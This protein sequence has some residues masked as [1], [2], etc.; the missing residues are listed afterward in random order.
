MKNSSLSGGVEVPL[1]TIPQTSQLQPIINTGLEV[2][3]LIVV[4]DTNISTI[5]KIKQ[6][7]YAVDRQIVMNHTQYLQNMESFIVFKGIKRPQ[8]LLDDYNEGK[9]VNFSQI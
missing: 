6:L 5:S 1:D 3:A 9:R 4:K 8:K 2:P 7:V